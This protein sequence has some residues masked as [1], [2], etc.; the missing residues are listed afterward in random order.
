VTTP[1]RRPGV[2]GRRNRHLPRAPTAR[3]RG[4]PVRHGNVRPGTPEWDAAVVA[5][6]ERAVRAGRL[7]EKPPGRL[8]DRLAD[9]VVLSRRERARRDR[10]G[11]RGGAQ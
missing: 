3:K 1:T 2:A 9:L 5:A 11:R 10:G 4:G 8:L 6:L 7:P